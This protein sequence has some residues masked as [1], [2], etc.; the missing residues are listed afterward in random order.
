VE[1]FKY[2][3][4][5]RVYVI[6]MK[7]INCTSCKAAGTL[8]EVIWGMP[9]GPVDESKYV[10]GGCCVSPDGNNATHLCVDCGWERL[11]TNNLL[12]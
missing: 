7:L 10:L 11:E 5:S 9:D 3:V 8:R 1:K 12:N 4:G 2:F 6:H